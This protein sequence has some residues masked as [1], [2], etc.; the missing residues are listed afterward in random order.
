M[1]F[2]KRTEL[3]LKLDQ[4]HEFI[5]ELIKLKKEELKNGSL[6]SK[7]DL[8]SALVNSNESSEENK[9]TMEEIRV[10]NFL[11]YFDIYLMITRII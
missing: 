8:I 1:P 6:N 11:F 2:F 10:N 5:Q 9:L 3:S 4:Y 7:R